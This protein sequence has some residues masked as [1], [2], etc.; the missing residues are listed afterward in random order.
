MPLSLSSM[1]TLVSGSSKHWTTLIRD[2]RGIGIDRAKW[3]LFDTQ[4]SDPR[5]LQI[6]NDI[7]QT[8]LWKDGMSWETVDTPQQ[9]E[10]DCGALSP[11]IAISYVR[12]SSK[13]DPERLNSNSIQV[14][15]KTEPVKLG[16]EARQLIRATA[17]QRRLPSRQQE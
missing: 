15:N 14:T 7:E 6:R 17:E 1:F 13:M 2:A 3:R 16:R 10:R 9:E 12:W 8:T 11:V 4:A 5:V